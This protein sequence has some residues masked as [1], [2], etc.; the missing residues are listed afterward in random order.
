MRLRPGL[1]VIWALCSA[2]ASPAQAH[3]VSTGLG[4][5]YDGIGHFL[6]S[7]ETLLPLL[8]VLLLAALNGPAAAR[9]GSLLLPVL[10]LVAGTAGVLSGVLPEVAG[11]VLAALV[12]I[13]AG[14]L[15]AMDRAWSRAGMVVMV[16]VGAVT[17]GYAEGSALRPLAGSW[18][19]LLGASAS[20]A[21]LA[22]LGSAA[23]VSGAAGALWRRMV[24]RV[25]GSW[26]A[27]IG[28]LLLGWQLRP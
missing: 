2:Q 11:T 3:L 20:L 18:L 16:S 15:V 8:A 14:A 6:L 9:L 25:S 22:S 21:V 7:M 12:R 27:G 26:L 23:V 4:P 1:S 28:L 13:V 5:V 17:L 10:W 24:L 19:M